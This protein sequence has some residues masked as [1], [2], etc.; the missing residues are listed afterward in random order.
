MTCRPGL[1]PAHTWHADWKTPLAHTGMVAKTPPFSH[2][3]ACW[4][5]VSILPVARVWSL[6]LF[7]TYIYAYTHTPWCG[8]DKPSWQLGGHKCY[9]TQYCEKKNLLKVVQADPSKDKMMRKMQKVQAGSL[10]I[11]KQTSTISATIKRLKSPKG[12]RRET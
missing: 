7:P 9:P 11:T 6:E 10:L 3:M 8:T 2:H 4:M 12:I 5:E 1:F